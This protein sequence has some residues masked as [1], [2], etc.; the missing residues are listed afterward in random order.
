M[1]CDQTRG[2]IGANHSAPVDIIPTPTGWFDSGDVAGDEQTK[3]LGVA[4]AEAHSSG[5]D[6]RNF[7]HN[8]G[9]WEKLIVHLHQKNIATAIVLLPTDASYHGHLDKAKVELMNRKLT[10]F[11]IKHHIKFIDYTDDARFSLNDFTLEMPDHMNARGAM[12]FSRILDEE[13]IKAQW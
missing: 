2:F 13:V 8:L 9:Y 10:E 6:T 7:G 1:Y 12:K 3:K 5:A 4:A 11:A